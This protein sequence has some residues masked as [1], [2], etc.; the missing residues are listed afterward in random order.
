MKDLN[1]LINNMEL[2][3]AIFALLALPTFLF[4]LLLFT[5]FIF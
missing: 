1:F 3:Q 2:G 5:D 4:M